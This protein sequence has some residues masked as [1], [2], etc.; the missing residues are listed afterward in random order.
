MA[1]DLA[2]NIDA[3][4]KTA[5][6]YA[7]AAINLAGEANDSVK[8]LVDGIDRNF[9]IGFA[10]VNPPT[11][12]EINN[13]S[14]KPGDWTAELQATEDI[15]I[16]NTSAP[17]APSLLDVPEIAVQEFLA[18]GDSPTLSFPV[19]P[20]DFDT[21]VPV[22]PGFDAPD[23]PDAPDFTLP[24]SPTLS[25]IVVPDTPT[26]ADVPV[27]DGVKPNDLVAPELPILSFI[28]D[29]YESELLTAAEA[30]L[31]DIVENG[32]TGLDASV[33]QAIFDR[34]LTREVV[35]ARRNLE[36]AI[37]EFAP[38]F[39]RP[40]GSL[41]ARIDTL[42]A[43]LQ[44]R[45]EDLNRKI[46][47]DQARLAQDNTQ[48][49]VTE[50]LKHEAVMIQYQ[51]AIAA[52]ALDFAKAVVANALAVYNLKVTEYQARLDG[53]KTDAQVFA[54]IIRA[55]TLEID[56]Y[57]AQLEAT[58]IEVDVNDSLVNVYQAQIQAVNLLSQFYNSQLAGVKITA[59]IEAINL[60]AYRTELDGYIATIRVKE[61][62]Y[63][64]Y[65]AGIDGESAKVDAY[66]AEVAS[67]RSANDGK[68]AA[69]A[70]DTAV[71]DGTLAVNREKLDVYRAEVDLYSIQIRENVE[72]IRG[73]VASYAAQAEAYRANIDLEKARAGVEIEGSKISLEASKF[74]QQEANDTFQLQGTL[75]VEQIKSAL[76]AAASSAS[77][78]NQLAA[79]A[80][81]Q[82]NTVS[83]ITSTED[84]TP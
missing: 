12:P 62:E 80:L 23:I 75:L 79:S 20:D 30:W 56:Q 10:G 26:F 49:G 42:R 52:R 77:S 82:I 33:E 60:E 40:S 24:T 7:D 58:K 22:S 28:E 59:D 69:I 65:K 44:N 64:A 11:I 38:G 5:Q 9:R 13:P 50:A 31:L 73:A 36:N 27:F 8:A 72:V 16:G 43:D 48:F 41:R 21:A 39:S 37:D 71:A 83:Q 29:V 67:I 35:A 32:G 25:T 76:A 34:E 53:Y 15:I 14:D 51:S 17:N 55:A 78:A 84:V 57:K 54:E 46:A 70:G 18:A 61:L 45:T 4:I 2:S 19:R 47:E 66:E 6:D 81:A 63:S 1:D 74:N 68:T 3:Q